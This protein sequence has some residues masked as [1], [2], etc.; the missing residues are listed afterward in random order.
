LKLGLSFYS[1]QRSVFIGIFL[2]S[3]ADGKKDFQNVD[4][5]SFSSGSP[6]TW[7][8]TGESL[9]L[10]VDHKFRHTLDFPLKI[11]WEQNDVAGWKKRLLKLR[12]C[13]KS[14]IGEVPKGRT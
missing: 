1:I 4:S 6:L 9:I 10:Q 11:L 5:T 8:K 12:I 2:K 3:V 7:K 13:R 14:E